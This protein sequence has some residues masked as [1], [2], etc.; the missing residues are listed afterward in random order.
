MVNLS[1]ALLVLKIA[2]L[3]PEGSSWVRLF[4]TWQAAV[5]ERTQGRIRLHFYTGGVMGDEKDMLRKIRLGQ[6][7]AAM[8]TG[9][10]LSAIIPEVRVFEVCRNYAELDHAREKLDALIRRRFEDRGFV[11][12]GWGDVGPV[13]LFSK[14]PIRSLEDAQQTRMWM[15][16]DDPLT[17]EGF[18]ALGLHGVPLGI[19]E[20]QPALATGTIDAFFGSP[21]STLAL[22]WWPHAK[23]VTSAVLGQATGAVVMAKSLFDGLAPGDRRALLESSKGMESAVLAQVRGDNDEA[24]RTLIANGLQVVVIPKAVEREMMMRVSRVAL[25]NMDLVMNAI[26]R[27]GASLEFQIAV[28][29]LLEEY[30]ETY[31]ELGPVLDEYDHLHGHPSKQQV[32]KASGSTPK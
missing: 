19:P 14:R 20:V 31:P 29:N 26:G 22:Q 25:A 9:I 10:G 18:K 28:R 1:A 32:S 17:R 3:A 15:F 4:R 5:E 24:M 8:I 30:R 21:L 2:S 7:G 27:S 11:L 23:Y 12:L 13:H 16:N 6:L